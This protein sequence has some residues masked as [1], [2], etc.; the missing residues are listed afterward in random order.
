MELLSEP[1]LETEF[2]SVEKSMSGRS[3]P[4]G[5]VSGRGGKGDRGPGVLLKLYALSDLA[6]GR[7]SSCRIPDPGDPSSG[8]LWSTVGDEIE[9]LLDMDGR[10]FGFEPKSKRISSVLKISLLRLPGRRSSVVS[11][12]SSLAES[13]VR[14]CESGLEE[15]I[16]SASVMGRSSTIA[17]PAPTGVLGESLLG[18]S[19]IAE[20]CA[21]PLNRDLAFMSDETPTASFGCFRGRLVDRLRE[22]TFISLSLCWTLSGE[23]V[24]EG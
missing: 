12:M 24:L 6:R 2:L 20:R 1:T 14:G 23:R 13:G 11:S 10:K 17:E 18:L 22:L 7:E 8:T 3:C 15:A 21:K 9:R 5:F 19:M 4:A 16:D